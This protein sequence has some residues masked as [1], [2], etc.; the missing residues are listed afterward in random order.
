[1]F[2]SHR[3]GRKASQQSRST[4]CRGFP[5]RALVLAVCFVATSAA[6][7]APPQPP[8]LSLPDAEALALRNHPLL[9]AANYNAR[10]AGQVTRERKSAYYPSATGNVTGVEALANS[11]IAAGALNNP[12]ILNRESNGL[13]VNQLI[14]DFGRTSN[15]VSSARFSAKAASEDVHQTQQDVLLAVNR[16]YFAVLRA[17]AVLQVAEETVKERQV[18][19][20]QVT[21]LEKNRLKSMLDV[22][23]AEVNLAQANLL[24]VQAQNDKQAA[25]A[26]LATTLGLANPQPFELSEEP[27][28][29]PP[30]ADAHK[31]G[32]AG[33][34]EPARPRQCALQP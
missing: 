31:P 15:L 14:T 30:P 2:A 34:S 22:S 7:A 25:D 1:M 33:A 18:L 6:F 20:D 8:K 29:A 26:E 13:E 28:P 3:R 11:R 23:F 16:A 12:L 24:L 9:Q 5:R 27:M 17:Q 19:A 32:G 21:T 4:S 10:A